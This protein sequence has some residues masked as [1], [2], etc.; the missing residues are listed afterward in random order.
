MASLTL[1]AD[2]DAQFVNGGN[3]GWGRPRQ[4]QA[5]SVHYSSTSYKSAKTNL[6]QGNLANNLAVGIGFLGMG[7]ASAT[8]VQEN[9]A[10]ITTAA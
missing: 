1:L 10:F 5:P 6:I 4:P 7:S 9:V 2:H 8:S 3:G